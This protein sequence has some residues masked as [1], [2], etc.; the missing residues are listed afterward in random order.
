MQ[1][2]FPARNFLL[3][4]S[5]LLGLV[6]AVIH[7]GAVVALCPLSINCWLKSILTLLDG[8]NLYFLLYQYVLPWSRQRV[9]RLR[10]HEAKW[11]VTINK[12]ETEVEFKVKSYV[13]NWL[14]ILLF[15]AQQKQLP[16]VI[17]KDALLADDYRR[18]KVLLKCLK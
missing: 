14:I 7:L 4:P 17:C 6:L 13:S 3:Q 9:I 8:L 11:F 15:R 10:F 12:I 16:V 1:R 5:K 18:L 2:H